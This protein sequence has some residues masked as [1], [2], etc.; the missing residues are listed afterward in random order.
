MLPLA[1]DTA[2]SLVMGYTTALTRFLQS[3]IAGKRPMRAMRDY[4]LEILQGVDRPSTIR[5]V[6][7]IH[8]LGLALEEEDLLRY[9][10]V[11]AAHD[12]AMRLMPVATDMHARLVIE[13]SK[14]KSTIADWWDDMMAI[15]PSSFRVLSEGSEGWLTCAVHLAVVAPTDK[16]LGWSN[17]RRSETFHDMLGAEYQ[18]L[19]SLASSPRLDTVLKMLRARLAVSRTIWYPYYAAMSDVGTVMA[20]MCHRRGRIQLAARHQVAARTWAMRAGVVATLSVTECRTERHGSFSIRGMRYLLTTAPYKSFARFLDS[21]RDI[22]S[23]RPAMRH[24]DAFASRTIV[25]S[26]FADMPPLYARVDDSRLMRYVRSP[27]KLSADMEKTVREVRDDLLATFT[28]SE[29]MESA[30]GPPV[31]AARPVQIGLPV[32]NLTDW[33][34]SMGMAMQVLSRTDKAHYHL[35]LRA[36]EELDAVDQETLESDTYD[37]LDQ[38]T[39]SFWSVVEKAEGPVLQVSESVV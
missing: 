7:L 25:S 12:V 35:A 22:P 26:V 24:A 39:K 34:K 16:W 19:Y 32:W 21:I 13:A 11:D 17:Y 37:S 5:M 27:A 1:A 29:P 33:P 14:R 20:E 4:M 15:M 18:R 2:E 30:P 23:C 6:W 36:F 28:P 38:F 3:S 9:F 8:W 31:V 10:D